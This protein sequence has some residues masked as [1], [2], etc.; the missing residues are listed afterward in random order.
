[1]SENTE[2]WIF[3]NNKTNVLNKKSI[4][5]LAQKNKIEL[6]F[7]MKFLIQIMDH[8]KKSNFAICEHFFK[9]FAALKTNKTI[10][11]AFL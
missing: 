7:L 6:K 8:L 5:F 10:H 2:K 4:T 3:N 1:M 11:S 9:S